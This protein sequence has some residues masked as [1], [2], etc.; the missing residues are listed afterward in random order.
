M[1]KEQ[2]VCLPVLDELVK[3]YTNGILKQV[4]NYDATN[5]GSARHGVS[6]SLSAPETLQTTGAWK[7]CG[8][9]RE[10]LLAGDV[11]AGLML[12]R[13]VCPAAF[14]VRYGLRLTR[15][16]GVGGASS[17]PSYRG[18]P[19]TASRM[20]GSSFAPRSRNS[21]SSFG[22]AVIQKLHWVSML[23]TA[24]FTAALM[25]RCG[26]VM[27]SVYSSYTSFYG[28][29]RQRSTVYRS[30][31]ARHKVQQLWLPRPRAAPKCR[32]CF[33]LRGFWCPVLP[34]HRRVDLAPLSRFLTS[35]LRDSDV[36][37]GHQA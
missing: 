6:W 32:H 26:H 17:H 34:L 14:E 35:V 31:Y 30:S 16:D 3:E 2:E 13:D 27:I 33:G 8:A 9:M 25:F 4:S 12:M 23:P 7:Q 20:Y 24:Q 19:L 29:P 1:A 36:L 15:P 21:S 5:P 10:A 11:D 22:R 28:D 18:A 37:L